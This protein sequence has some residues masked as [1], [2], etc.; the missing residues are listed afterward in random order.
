MNCP[1]CDAAIDGDGVCFGG[2][3]LSLNRGYIYP[4]VSVNINHHVSTIC[5]QCY[6]EE[7]AHRVG[8]AVQAL[9]TK[10]ELKNEE[11]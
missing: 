2:T 10:E 9:L 1:L 3:E 8:N 6:R 4:R 7:L 11:S 5:R